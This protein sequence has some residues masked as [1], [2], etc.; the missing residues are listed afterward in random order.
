MNFYK[1]SNRV[2]ME[3]KLQTIQSTL[4]D[5]CKYADDYTQVNTSS[6]IQAMERIANNTQADINLFD[7]YGK[8]MR[9]T[10]PELFD[11]YLL[12]SRMNAQA[13]KQIVL[14]NKNSFFNSEILGKLSYYSLYAPIFNAEVKLLAIA[15]IPYFSKDEG[16]TEDEM[17]AFFSLIPTEKYKDY[18]KHLG[19]SGIRAHRYNEAEIKREIE[20]IC[21]NS[22]KGDQLKEEMYRLF[23]VGNRYTKADI[24]TTLKNLYERIGYQKTAKATDLEEYF[25]LKKIYTSD[26]KNG[27]EL[28][29]K[30]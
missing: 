7:P 3:E 6:V 20:K 16:F 15:N 19:F 9:S 8:L 28:L 1:E 2:Q 14:E 5:I 30:K 27:F 26:K 11:R 23:K 22:Q 10:Q 12:S 25:D 18:Y 17:D 24:K 4:S 29:N 13:Y 21:G